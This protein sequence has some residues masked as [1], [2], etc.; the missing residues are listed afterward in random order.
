MNMIPQLVYVAMMFLGLGISM[1]KHGQQGDHGK[2]NCLVDLVSQ[3]LVAALLW[4]GGF[5]EPLMAAMGAR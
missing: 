4:W 5:F 1:A 2:H 3:V